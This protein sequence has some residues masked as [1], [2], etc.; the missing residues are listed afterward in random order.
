MR[1][2]RYNAKLNL[3]SESSIC[4]SGKG[5]SEKYA[6]NY[7]NIPHN[8]ISAGSAYFLY[9]PSSSS[10]DALRSPSLPP[11]LNLSLFKYGYYILANCRIFETSHQE[12]Y[13]RGDQNISKAGK[14][15]FC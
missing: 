7:G 12:Q 10:D 9:F 4:L 8:S 2:R 15:T 3:S 14:L 5:N 6:M 1:S 13:F 11:L